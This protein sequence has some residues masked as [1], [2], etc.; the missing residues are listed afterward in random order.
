MQTAVTER[1]CLL[2]REIR[3]SR[4]LNRPW[5]PNQMHAAPTSYSSGV[6]P[7]DISASRIA[8]ASSRLRPLDNSVSTPSDTVS[9]NRVCAS[10]SVLDAAGGL[11]LA[12]PSSS[13]DEAEDGAISLL[14][15]TV[16]AAVRLVFPGWEFYGLPF[17]FLIQRLM[18]SR[19]CGGAGP[20][21]RPGL[22]ICSNA[23][24]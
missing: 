10:A 1:P 18:K 20:R 11:L 7:S 15:E 8:P 13:G 19:S 21:A 5:L 16:F 2:S 6:D 22:K 17:F 4:S 24:E 14:M 3:E 9:S 12:L 23:F